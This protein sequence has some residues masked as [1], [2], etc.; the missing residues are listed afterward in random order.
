MKR[1]KE[2]KYLVTDNGR[3][4][5][6]LSNAFLQPIERPNGYLVVDIHGES[7]PVHRLV[8]L[9]YIPNPGNKPY[10]NHKNFD[11]ADNTVE[12]LEWVTPKEN[13][14]HAQ[15]AGKYNMGE[16]V[17]TAVLTERTAIEAAQLLREGY[18]T[19]KVAEIFGVTH[20]TVTKLRKGQ[21]WKYL[22]LG[23]ENIVVRKTTNVKKLSGEDIP[24]IRQL[25]KDGSTNAEI[26]RLFDVAPATIRHIRLGKTW[27]II[28]ST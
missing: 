7:I 25:F 20:S 13:S 4:F 15:Q 18:S 16:K 5:S 3:V 23:L 21:T 6:E 1:Y 24:Y 2:T 9:V 17:N 26:A 11:K 19:A 28:K 8:A 14:E 22:D 10:V 27:S 12:N